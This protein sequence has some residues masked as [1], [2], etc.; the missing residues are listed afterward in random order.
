M[1]QRRRGCL[2]AGF[3]ISI[4][5]ASQPSHAQFTANL[6]TNIISG[7]TSN[8]TGS[9]IVGSNTVA[10]TLL[11]Q[12]SGV[13]S[14]ANGYLGY[15]FTGT[16]NSV[17][18]NGPGSIWNNT[19]YLYVGYLGAGN[20]LVITNGGHVVDNYGD[21]DEY[22]GDTNN[23]VLVTGSG[24]LWSNSNVLS[25]G[26]YY[27][28]ANSVVIRN[29]GQV[30]CAGAYVTGTNAMLVTD[31][32]TV[33]NSG[34]GL[35]AGGSGCAL[36]VSNGGFVM[37][38]SSYVDGKGAAALITD[39]G[40]VWSN[41]GTL[42]VG[43][44]GGGFHNNSLVISNG[45]LV[46]SAYGYVG[47]NPGSSSNFVLVTGPGSVWSNTGTLTVGFYGATNVVVIA[48]AGQVFSGNGSVGS[49]ASN[50]AFVVTGTSSMWSIG[51]GL[52]IGPNA[53]H[54]SLV[55][56]NGG[57]VADVAANVGGTTSNMVLVTDSGSVWSNSD[58][59]TIG[60][61]GVANSVII[62]NGGRLVT[63]T[64]NIGY[65][66]YGTG[67]RVTVTGTGSVWY[68]SGSLLVGGIA[69]GGDSLTIE[70]GGQVVDTI[71][72]VIFGYPPTG[73]CT[74][75]VTGPGSIWSN[76]TLQIIGTSVVSNGGQVVSGVVTIS[77][78]TTTS[79]VTSGAAF[80]GTNVLM[81]GSTLRDG[82]SVIV[83]DAT[84]DATLEVRC[85]TFILDGGLLQVDR[86]VMTNSCG[87]FVR[88]GGTVI[89][90]TL[91]LDPNLSALGDGIPNG[92]KQQYGLDPLDSTLA[93]R[94]LDG[95][96]FTVLQD[97]LAGVDP[98]NPAASFRITSL[99]PQGNDLLVTWNMGSGK[100]NAL[101]ATAGD[102]NG[103]YNTNNFTD[104]FTV[105]N[106]VGSVTN[107]LDTGA[108]TN[109][110]ARYY[111]VRLVP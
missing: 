68:N 18:V 8:W 5:V 53:G 63:T 109:V 100:T 88:N 99:V 69:S 111:R 62:S 54:N 40:S 49:Y 31:P 27:G 17:V 20:S 44:V 70:N 42:Y 36:V 35:S 26:P 29:G 61:D 12:N 79:R 90:G 33:W 47:N 84:H 85:G 28:P 50:N 104:I 24:S 98:T 25:V 78:V 71:G 86:L 89:V 66:Y 110:P 19:N 14:N 38:V 93:N 11:I 41:T 51:G 21:V 80:I 22:Y 67:N 77:G 45:A 97:Y 75:L 76:Q 83:T 102:A 52:G 16:N 64:G 106:T 65:D 23:S 103:G 101:Q 13:L 2:T 60:A 82:G 10:D 74:A 91:V 107:Y 30:I 73:P 7:V 3:L 9:Y 58:T 87:L 105:T 32:G 55:V 48:D 46:V 15:D 39:P 1:R 95:T 34:G 56:S 4:A 57:Q 108:A 43:D 92:W 81:T 72:S 59:L 6:Q 37:D 94:D 96:G